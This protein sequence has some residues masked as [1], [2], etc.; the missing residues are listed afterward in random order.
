M[1]TAPPTEIIR[2][3]IIY[4][5]MLKLYVDSV[6]TFDGNINLFISNYDFLIEVYKTVTDPVFQHYFVKIIQSKLTGYAY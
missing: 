3:K 2:A 6:R 4:K 5:H 1:E